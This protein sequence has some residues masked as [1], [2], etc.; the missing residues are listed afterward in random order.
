MKIKQFSIFVVFV[1]VNISIY[2]QNV[3]QP[4][5]DSII[6][7]TDIQGNKQGKWIRK[8]SKDKIAYI[9]YF[10]NNKLVGTYKRWY[11]SGALKAE[12]NYNDDGSVGYAKLYWDNGKIMAKG[13]YINQNIKDSMWEFYGIDGALMS[14][15]SYK[16]GVLDGISYDYFRSGNLSRLAPYTNGKLDGIY[17]EFWQDIGIVRLEIVYKNG[18]RNGPIRVYYFNGKPYLIGNYV[19]DLPD[20][21]WI[22]YTRDGR[23]D[24]EIEYIN[25]IRKDQDEYDR[26]FTKK[27]LEWEKMRGK[28]PEP[29]ENDFFNS[30]RKSAIDFYEY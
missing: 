4:G 14:R 3:G 9:G 2:S 17:K 29:N 20:G 10:K 27:I 11:F 28:I 25:G 26:E 23:I 7:Y 21:K 30:K 12:I 18:V 16:N 13:K 8:Y 22:Y 5:N 24:K 19:N 1:V 6:N 15:V